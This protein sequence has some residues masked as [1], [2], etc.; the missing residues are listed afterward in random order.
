ME[1]VFSEQDIP[2]IAERIVAGL[3][4]TVCIFNGEM[5]TGKTT[6]I[7]AICQKLGV[8]QSMSS[9]TYA[10]VNEYRTHTNKTIYHFDLYRIK[11]IE[12]L[13]DIGFEEYIDSESLCFIEWPETAIPLL[14]KNYHAIQLNAIEKGNRSLKFV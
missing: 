5:G 2:A 3:H 4:Y 6:L 9:P 10:I 13:L 11:A 8:Q 7:K 12:E 14:P 1:I